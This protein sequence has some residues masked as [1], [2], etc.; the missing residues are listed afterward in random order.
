M[1]SWLL[2]AYDGSDGA[3]AAAAFGLWLAAKAGC[4]MTLAH[5]VPSRDAGASA[6]LLPAGADQALAYQAEWQRRLENLRD[7]AAEDAA[8]DCRIVSGTPAGALIAAAA[9]TGAASCWPAHTVRGA[10]AARCWAAS[11]RSC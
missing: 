11:P 8:V 4:R 10:C 7:Y 6:D 5:V 2:V 3:D 9:E 1:L